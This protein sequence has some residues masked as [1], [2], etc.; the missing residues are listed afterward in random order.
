LSFDKA[1]IKWVAKVKRAF[2]HLF[3]SFQM[4]VSISNL[5][6][7]KPDRFLKPVRFA[8]AGI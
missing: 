5:Q 3:V 8:V 4:G 2:N 1:Q 6:T 7:F